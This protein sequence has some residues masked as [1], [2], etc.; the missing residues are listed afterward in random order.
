M[1]AVVNSSD[2]HS[3]NKFCFSALIVCYSFPMAIVTL[4]AICSQAATCGDSL[5]I[6]LHYHGTESNT[7]A[8]V[9]IGLLGDVNHDGYSDVAIAQLGDVRGTNVVYGGNPTDSLTDKF[10]KGYFEGAVD[11][12]GDGIVDVVT[13]FVRTQQT[14]P[15]GVLYFFQGFTD[16][17]ATDPYDSLI[18]PAVDG[19]GIGVPVSAGF[20]DNDSLGDLLVSYECRSEGPALSYY[21]GCPSLDTS[22][23]WTF[24]IIQASHDF[25]G[26]GFIDFNGDGNQDVFIGMHADL[27]TL[28]YVYI[29]FGPQFSSTPDYVI[30]RPSNITGLNGEEFA[31]YVA[32]IGDVNGDGWSDLGVVYDF[33]SLVYFGGPT[34]DGNYNEYLVGRSHV[35]GAAGDIN[36]DGFNDL[37]CGQTR[38]FDG[39]VDAYLG[40]VSLDNAYD[41]S[42]YSDDLP[43][44]LLQDIG[45]NVSMAGDFNGDGFGDFMFSCRN[46]VGG[47]PG[48]VFVIA[49]A[50]GILTGIDEQPPVTVPTSP[51][52]RQNFPN[53]FNGVTSI[54]FHLDTAEDLT[55]KVFNSLGQHVATL[56]NDLH[57]NAGDHRLAWSGRLDGGSE[58][59]SGIYFCKL[60]SKGG[61]S[62]IKMLLL[63]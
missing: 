63:R 15:P 35:M 53:P 27:D 11:L 30:Q 33:Q 45:Y 46:F 60:N 28:S 39:A 59:P 43:P 7:Y 55:I 51:V 47:L 6:L 5:K 16:S 14:G 23:D 57:F 13:S 9:K 37:V 25:R 62:Q 3:K 61:R 4:A 20:A 2:H 41:C 36:G 17:L 38:T 49:G 29:F 48:D 22:V 8:G 42:V 1:Q 18:V 19:C 24:E 44:A 54:E 58:A 32:N 21:S 12:N 52:L 40:G 34:G 10:L 31:Q 26:F 56:A 50:P